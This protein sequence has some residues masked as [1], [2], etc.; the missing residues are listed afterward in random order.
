[1][2]NFQ[3]LKIWQKAM[4]I[5]KKVYLLSSQFPSEEKYGLTSQIRRSAISIASNIAEGAGRN[6]NGEFKNFL[7]IA[8]GSSNELCT[9]LILSYRLNLISEDKI[10]PVI[11]ELIEIQ[12]MNYT[13]IRKFSS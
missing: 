4:D 10:Q 2:H 6:T 13:L 3:N 11:E 12:K 1:M 7:G 8:N 9:Q 5:A